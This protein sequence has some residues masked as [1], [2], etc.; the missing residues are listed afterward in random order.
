MEK[1]VHF[2][3]TTIDEIVEDV[4]ECVCQCYTSRDCM[5]NCD[6]ADCD[7]PWNPGTDTECSSDSESDF[8][9]DY[10]S[11]DSLDDVYE[12]LGL[13]RAEKKQLQDQFNLLLEEAELTSE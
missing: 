1:S 2:E 11:S 9:S 5:C 6:C 4:E 7:P 3:L 10:D 12:E 13:T 8:E